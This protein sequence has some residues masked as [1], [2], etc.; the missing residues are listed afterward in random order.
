MPPLSTTAIKEIKMP[1]F[2]TSAINS[3]PKAIVS[4]AG[5]FTFQMSTFSLPALSSISGIILDVI[6]IF[7]FFFKYLISV[8]NSQ[9]RPTMEQIDRELSR[10]WP[11][12]PKPFLKITLGELLD[13]GDRGE[14]G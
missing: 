10:R 5:F 13:H 2:T 7:F 9:S 12:L 14:T 6:L 4:V 8:Q 3:S 1:P 11:P